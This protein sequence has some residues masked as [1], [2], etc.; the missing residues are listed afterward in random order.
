M[1]DILFGFISSSQISSEE[2]WE[3]ETKPDEISH[4]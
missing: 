1:C 3:D 4:I 2:V